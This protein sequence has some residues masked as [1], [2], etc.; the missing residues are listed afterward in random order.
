MQDKMGHDCNVRNVGCDAVKCKYNDTDKRK[1]VADSIK[2]GGLTSSN[3]Q[4]TF[5]ATF[6]EK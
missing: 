4:D 3:K 6:S 1:C 2:V 5:C